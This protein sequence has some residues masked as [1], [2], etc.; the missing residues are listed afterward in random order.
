MA[1]SHS[2]FIG[3]FIENQMG[4]VA[5]DV[6]RASCITADTA[7]VVSV[8]HSLFKSNTGGDV[9]FARAGATIDLANS[10]FRSNGQAVAADDRRRR[11][12]TSETQTSI[13]SDELSPGL[14]EEKLSRLCAETTG[15]KHYLDASYPAVCAGATV[16]DPPAFQRRRLASSM[17]VGAVIVL[18]EGAVARIS[19]TSFSS[20]IGLSAGAIS[21]SGEG[22]A[23]FLDRVDFH[24]NTAAAS[25]S[26][27]GALHVSGGATV[28]GINTV[29]ANN[30]AASQLAAG[31]VYTSSGADVVLTDSVLSEN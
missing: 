4:L 21:V 8:D 18:V 5:P 3:S 9:I 27:G 17:Q 30:S 25:D 31:A 28:R 12:L 6:P 20:N 23:A 2:Y 10:A 14:S 24:T 26:A 7:S 19:D 15:W 29:F 13:A 1:V 16:L 11:R 22:T